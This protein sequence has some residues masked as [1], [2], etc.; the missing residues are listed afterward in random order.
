[1]A[2]TVLLIE[3]EPSVGELVR[4]YLD[5]DGYRVIWVRSG[6][7]GLAELD[8]H[9]V[10]I[11]ILD[12]GL[13]GID[14]FEVCRAMRARSAVPILMLTARDEEPDRVVGL[15]VGADDYLTKPFSPRELV[16]RLKAILRRTDP[17]PAQEVLALGDVV[18]NRETHDVTTGGELVELTAK[19][20]E[21]LAYFLSNPNAVLSRDVLLDRVWG[22]EYPG[23]TRTVD[24]HVA[25]LRR[26]LGRPGLI[27]TLRGS[28]YKAVTS[29]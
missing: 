15:E 24:V 2:G 6:E 12:L 10:R 13:P 22:V 28:G 26:K 7:E 3:D 14:G 18:L 4:A 29:T 8:R 20:F 19:E 16:A 11:V 23:G 1:M 27:R 17:P 5:R 21:L 9:P 25:Q